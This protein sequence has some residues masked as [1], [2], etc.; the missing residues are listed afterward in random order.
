MEFKN[1]C[2]HDIEIRINRNE[3]IVIPQ[4][5]TI[6]RIQWETQYWKTVGSI[7][8]HFRSIKNVVGMPK[9]KSGVLYVVSNI[10]QEQLSDERTDLVSPDRMSAFITHG[11]VK[12]V[13]KLVR[14]K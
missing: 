11:K 9:E 8:I 6:A 5:D 10:V 1:L 3:T 2:P 12:N 4:S 7:P 13:E 14:W